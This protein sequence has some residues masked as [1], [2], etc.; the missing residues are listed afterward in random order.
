MNDSS[1]NDPPTNGSQLSRQE[2]VYGIVQ[3]DLASDGRGEFIVMPRKVAT[4]LDRLVTGLS[5]T[6]WGELR[7]N[8]PE[9]YEQAC[10][11]GQYVTFEAYLDDPEGE[12]SPDQREKARQE[13]DALE[14]SADDPPGDDQPFSRTDIGAFN[15]GVWPTHWREA[16]KRFLPRGLPERCGGEY[17]FDGYH[18]EFPSTSKDA[19]LKEL[20]GLG[21]ICVKDQ[22]LLRS[23]VL[24]TL[25]LW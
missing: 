25:G 5:C 23:I 22:A 7:R 16:Q 3:S 17:G 13:Y 24:N 1:L 12:A 9:V 15:D 2:V 14:P 4:S 18:V 20:T 21:Y 6:T 10:E 11:Y 19:V 8:Y